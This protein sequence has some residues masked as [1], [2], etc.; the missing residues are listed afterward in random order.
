VVTRAEFVDRI[1]RRRILVGV[2]IRTV[3]G[4][5]LGEGGATTVESSGGD[6]IRISYGGGVGLTSSC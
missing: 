3:N 6:K 4:H 5:V 2:A 1:R